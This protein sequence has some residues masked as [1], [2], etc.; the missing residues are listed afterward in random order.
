MLKK[1]FA[2]IAAAAMLI[3]L[4]GCSDYVMTEED[5]AVQKSI[6]GYWVAD[7]STGYNEFAEDGTLTLMTVVEFTDDFHYL[8]H[9]CLL[10]EGYALTYP[11]VAYSF[12]DQKFKV[13]TD[14]VPSYARL[15]VSD[16]G[17]AM[18]WYT[19]EKTDSY[20]R[21]SKE[22]AAS[23]G[24][25]E[26]SPEAWVTDENGNYINETDAETYD[27]EE[28]DTDKD[29][30]AAEAANLMS[31]DVTDFL[32]NYDLSDYTLDPSVKFKRND[33]NEIWRKAPVVIAETEDS[34]IVL[35]GICI[36][37]KDSFVF[38]DHDGTVDIYEQS[39]I[40]P[41]GIMP[42]LMYSDIDSDGEK[43]LAVY[44]YVGSGTGLSV[45]SLVIYELEDGRFVPYTYDPTDALEG[46]VS[47]DIDNDAHTVTFTLLTSG[48]SITCEKTDEYYPDGIDAIYWGSLIEYDF[49]DG[50]IMLTAMPGVRWFYECMPTVRAKVFYSSAEPGKFGLTDIVM[51]YIEF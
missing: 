35:Y 17:Q 10:N 4:S 31:Y 36:D 41:R 18:Q 15:S 30:A 45:D 24:I 13:V 1:I 26:Y 8:L 5:L 16:D 6:E 43:E 3:C 21:L 50:E 29:G 38:I 27:T 42:E 49:E 48:E 22:D 7:S 33:E 2:L 51:E 44:Y 9:K 11:P 12:E 25:P 46:I 32:E 39:W 47:A 37:G 14:G 28:S 40:T 19:D 34:E 23:F 20:L